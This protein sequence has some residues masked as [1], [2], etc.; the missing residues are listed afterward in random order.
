MSAPRRTGQIRPPWGGASRVVSREMAR[1]SLWVFMSTST[2][3]PRCNSDPIFDGP[4][5][6]PRLS[7]L[8]LLLWWIVMSASLTST[9]WPGLVAAFADG[10][11]ISA[12]AARR[13][14]TLSLCFFSRA[15]LTPRSIYRRCSTKA[16]SPP[17]CSGSFIRGTSVSRD[18]PGLRPNKRLR[19]KM[20]AGS[21]ESGSVRFTQ[22]AGD[23]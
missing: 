22:H 21:D 14:S 4:V 9:R 2:L 3:K 20:L 16:F 1:S 8:L 23:L 6:H 7:L 10:R 12:F 19:G 5:H 11:V 18:V 13:D 17:F 15:Y